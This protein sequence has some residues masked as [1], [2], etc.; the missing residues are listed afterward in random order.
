MLGVIWYYSYCA[1]SIVSHCDSWYVLPGPIQVESSS[2]TPPS[3]IPV[4]PGTIPTPW[5]S[6][7]S[8]SDQLILEKTRDGSVK[9]HP[10]R[11]PT[12]STDIRVLCNHIQRQLGLSIGVDGAGNPRADASLLRVLQKKKRDDKRKALA[13]E[14]TPHKM[15]AIADIPEADRPVDLLAPEDTQ[16]NRGKDRIDDTIA[17]NVHPP[18]ARAAAVLDEQQPAQEKGPGDDSDSEDS[19]SNSSSSLSDSV[20][21]VNTSTWPSDF[22]AYVCGLCMLDAGFAEKTP[23]V[24]RA[25]GPGA[26]RRVEWKPLA[27][28]HLRNWRVVFHTDSAKSY[29]LRVGGVLQDRVVHAKKRCW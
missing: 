24:K 23:A 19:S 27:T 4:S 2:A 5:A 8:R 18:E 6:S 26:V 10:S 25:P 22:H 14:D 13:L 1:S 12:S 20:P 9:V 21:D 11:L 28:K 29:K 17:A 7:I 16:T 15:L 3:D